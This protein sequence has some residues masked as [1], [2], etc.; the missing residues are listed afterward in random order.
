MIE[1]NCDHCR[2]KVARYIV[3]AG[4]R[5]RCPHCRRR[6]DVPERQ[7]EDEEDDDEMEEDRAERK[8]KADKSSKKLADAVGL[9]GG[10]V[11]VLAVLY[12]IFKKTIILVFAP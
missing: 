4:K 8:R 10:C 1:F 12:L 7:V 11:F 3:D 2:R 5:I 9:I 6:T